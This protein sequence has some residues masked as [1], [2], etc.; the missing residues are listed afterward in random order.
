MSKTEEVGLSTEQLQEVLL[1]LHNM[2]TKQ[3]NPEAAMF[4]INMFVGEGEE[5]KSVGFNN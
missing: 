5:E 1:S 3:N 4:L 2:A